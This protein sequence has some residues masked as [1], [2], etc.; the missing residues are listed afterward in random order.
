MEK[1]TERSTSEAKMII[2]IRGRAEPAQIGP[3]LPVSVNRS[4]ALTSLEAPRYLIVYQGM[5]SDTSIITAPTPAAI[6]FGSGKAR[7]T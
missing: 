3:P 5:A 6:T 2:K 1:R 7:S 4:L